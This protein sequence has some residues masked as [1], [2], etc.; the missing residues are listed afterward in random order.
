VKLQW[1]HLGGTTPFLVDR[2][3]NQSSRMPNVTARMRLTMRQY[4][5]QQYYDTG[6]SA[7]PSN[8]AVADE[9]ATLDRVVYGTDWPWVF[10]PEEGNDPQPALATL[11]A[12]REKVDW[13]NAEV[14]VPRLVAR[15]LGR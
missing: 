15:V 3:D 6:M 2:I 12:E 13:R 8:L 10:L 14:L 11:G 7:T 5:E 1:A 9:L 4:F